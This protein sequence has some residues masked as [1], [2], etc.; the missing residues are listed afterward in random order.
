MPE[1][2]YRKPLRGGDFDP[3]PAFRSADLRAML[4]QTLCDSPCPLSFSEISETLPA[5]LQVYKSISLALDALAFEG[6]I[7]RDRVLLSPPDSPVFY[8]VKDRNKAIVS[9]KGLPTRRGPG[10]PRKDRKPTLL[11]VLRVIGAGGGFTEHQLVSADH[12]RNSV[13]HCLL[14]LIENQVVDK[15]YVRNKQVRTC[16]YSVRDQKAAQGIVETQAVPFS[17]E[18]QERRRRRR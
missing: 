17:L 15:L 14:V 8:R 9:R 10:T 4:Y 1:P 2:R 18:C 16:L 3:P 6:A 11:H 13:R 7:S 12:N 5:H